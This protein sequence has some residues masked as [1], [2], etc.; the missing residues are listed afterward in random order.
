MRRIQFSLP[1]RKDEKTLRI[2]I[3][4]DFEDNIKNYFDKLTSDIKK[5]ALTAV[6]QK[7]ITF[8]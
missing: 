6:L 4:I 8:I 5:I 3:A 7:R 2:Y 1:K